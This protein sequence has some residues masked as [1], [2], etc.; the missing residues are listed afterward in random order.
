MRSTDQRLADAEASLA[1][2][3]DRQRKD[4][5]RQMIIL[6]AAMLAEARRSVGF[7]TW[8]VNK[9]ETSMKPADVGTMRPLINRVRD[10]GAGS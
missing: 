4:H 6:G 10:E 7:R 1:R 5:T 3:R 9:L 8:L 2:L